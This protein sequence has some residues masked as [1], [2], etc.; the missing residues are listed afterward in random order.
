MYSKL[1]NWWRQL[2]QASE[3]D[4]IEDI[5]DAKAT[6]AADLR[7]LLEDLADFAAT[8]NLNAVTERIDGL[9]AAR[10]AL[11]QYGFDQI[12]ARRLRQLRRYLQPGRLASLSA[13]ARMMLRK[14]ELQADLLGG[15]MWGKSLR[16][17]SKAVREIDT[18]IVSL[19]GGR[20]ETALVRLNNRAVSGLVAAG[21]LAVEPIGRAAELAADILDHPGKRY[22]LPRITA[23]LIRGFLSRDALYR[24]GLETSWGFRLYLPG[25]GGFIG[26]WGLWH[27]LYT[28]TLRDYQA[29]AVPFRNNPGSTAAAD[30]GTLTVNRPGFGYG[31]ATPL[32]SAYLDRARYK[33]LIG[34]DG[35]A[36]IRIGYWEGRG[37][38]FTIS[39]SIPITPFMNV[40]WNASMFSPGFGPLVT[41][42]TPLA[43][44]LR[45]F[46]DRIV[47]R[48]VAPF[49]RVWDRVRGR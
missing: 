47:G 41:W 12:S 44:R 22:R 15:N 36:Y 33:L 31:S 24:T 46:T 48:A 38:Y 1:K 32:A 30:F 45:S 43:R 16:A 21:S 2:P 23:R 29:M 35:I 7:E 39:A 6:F 4:G 3:T 20:V 28:G 14:H 37:P 40:T 11:G 18:R 8:H 27:M 10:K 25:T 17:Q 26:N 19:I 49:R 9:I 34:R 13:V 42:S 5:L